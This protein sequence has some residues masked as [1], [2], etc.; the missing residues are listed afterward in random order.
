[1]HFAIERYPEDRASYHVSAEI[2]AVPEIKTWPD[3]GLGD[4]LDDFHAREILHVTYGSV[5]NDSRLQ[6]PFFETLLKNEDAY[7]EFVEKHFDRHF[8]LFEARTDD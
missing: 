7:T 8:R 5:L 4:L 2:F 6:R 1:M 3:D